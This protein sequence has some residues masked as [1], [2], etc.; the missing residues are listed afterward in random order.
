MAMPSAHFNA[1]FSPES[2]VN[3]IA[4]AMLMADWYF[5]FLCN[6]KHDDKPSSTEEAQCWNVL[7]EL[8][9]C[10]FLGLQQVR[11]YASSADNMTGTR[12]IAR[13]V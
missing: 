8:V 11:V 2:E 13:F 10:V 12:R 5:T 9:T 1:V 7:K 4:D 3:K 6:I